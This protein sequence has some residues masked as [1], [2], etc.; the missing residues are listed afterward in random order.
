MFVFLF[1]ECIEPKLE[2]TFEV[3]IVNVITV[4]FRIDGQQINADYDT[5]QLAAEHI[6]ERRP[7]VFR[8]AERYVQQ[9]I[10]LLTQH[11]E[12]HCDTR[13]LWRQQ[14]LIRRASLLALLFGKARTFD[15]INY[16]GGMRAKLLARTARSFHV[17]TAAFRM[18]NQ[19]AA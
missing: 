2:T 13:C 15:E 9:F 10:K 11:V 19:I 5:R 16:G 14:V 3:F 6:V 17:H 8:I 12:G 1:P 18:T 7:V 4:Q